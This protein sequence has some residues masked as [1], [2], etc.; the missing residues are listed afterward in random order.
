MSDEYYDPQ[1][2]ADSEGDLM[3]QFSGDPEGYCIECGY[4][5]AF[6]LHVRKP[7]VSLDDSEIPF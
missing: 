2:N 3:H 1:D 6:Y 4:P 7:P 5:E